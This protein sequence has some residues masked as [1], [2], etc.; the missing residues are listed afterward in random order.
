[1]V[2]EFKSCLF[3]YGVSFNENDDI[4][5]KIPKGKVAQLFVS[6]Y[7]HS[8]QKLIGQIIIVPESPQKEKSKRPL[9]KLL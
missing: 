1:M 3:T 7:D 8:S 9:D 6:L 5:M 2:Q 4:Q